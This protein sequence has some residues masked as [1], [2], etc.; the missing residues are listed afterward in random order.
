MV[1]AYQDITIQFQLYRMTGR[2][3]SL[4]ALILGLEIAV[5]AAGG[6]QASFTPKLKI[7][8]LGWGFPAYC[9]LL[10]IPTLL[11]IKEVI[12]WRISRWKM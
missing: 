6:T 4:L 1:D 11:H 9:C 10:L 7:S 3:Y 2:D 5:I 12:A 8:P